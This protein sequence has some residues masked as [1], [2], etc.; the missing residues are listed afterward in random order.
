M[1]VDDLAVS[2]NFDREIRSF[3]ASTLQGAIRAGLAMA[4]YHFSTVSMGSVQSSDATVPLV[5]DQMEPVGA[6]RHWLSLVSAFIH[7]SFSMVVG[8]ISIIGRK[9]PLL[10]AQSGG[11]ANGA[12][13][14]LIDVGLEMSSVPSSSPR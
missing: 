1:V 6:V 3:R 9:Y 11:A 14:Q 2:R 4:M 13:L 5:H 12:F 10:L 7:W 8:G